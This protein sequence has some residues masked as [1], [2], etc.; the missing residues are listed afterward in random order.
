MEE[1]GLRTL[2]GIKKLAADTL[3]IK[4]NKKLNR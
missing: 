2:P 1:K 3:K 4:E